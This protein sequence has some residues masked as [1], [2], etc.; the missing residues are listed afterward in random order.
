MEIKNEIKI[1]CKICKEYY[2]LN[3]SVL[4]IQYQDCICG[5]CATKNLDKTALDLIF[6]KQKQDRENESK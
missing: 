2:R 6:E 3:N 5:D 4:Y 1:Q